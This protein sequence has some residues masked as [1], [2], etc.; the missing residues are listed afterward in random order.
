[1]RN[2]GFGD[3]EE[4]MDIGVEH[5]MPLLGGELGDVWHSVLCSVVQGTKND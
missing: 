1:M 5:I 2:G 4:G 3:V